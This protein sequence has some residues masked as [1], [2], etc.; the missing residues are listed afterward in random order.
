[1][2]FSCSPTQP[3]KPQKEGSIPST[4]STSALGVVAVASLAPAS[5]ALKGYASRRLSRLFP[6][7]GI[8][9]LYSRYSFAHAPSRA[10]ETIFRFEILARF[11]TT[12]DFD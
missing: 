5:S 1:M 6:Q 2:R 7:A 11:P 12:T 8:H 9:S 3:P 10:S 4:R